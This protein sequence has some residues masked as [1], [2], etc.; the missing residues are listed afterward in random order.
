MNIRAFLGTGL[1]SDGNKQKN[2]HACQIE[3]LAKEQA[4]E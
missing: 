4:V 1:P 3:I 2:Q